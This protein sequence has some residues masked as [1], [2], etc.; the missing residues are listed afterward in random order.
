M[1]LR[2]YRSISKYRYGSIPSVVGWSA[3]TVTNIDDHRSLQRILLMMIINEKKNVFQ[4]L[5]LA[6]ALMEVGE[7]AE[8]EVASRFAYGETGLPPDVP[9]G[10]SILYTVE[11]KKIEME[12]AIEELDFHRK[13][14]I[15]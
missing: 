9:P 6:I 7:V 2:K 1:I 14:E 13:K 15:G 4:G 10:A 12:T 11:L 8:I 5:D 3:F